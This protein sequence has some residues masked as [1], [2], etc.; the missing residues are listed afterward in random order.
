MAIFL[1]QID[2]PGDMKRN[3]P[4]EKCETGSWKQNKREVNDNK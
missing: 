4:S 2:P 3:G 1:I